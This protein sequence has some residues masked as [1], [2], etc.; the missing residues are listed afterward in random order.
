VKIGLPNIPPAVVAVA[1]VLLAG[2]LVPSS[3]RAGERE[4]DLEAAAARAGLVK[5]H[6][7][8]GHICRGVVYARGGAAWEAGCRHVAS[9][10]GV[11]VIQWPAPGISANDSRITRVGEAEIHGDPD[12]VARVLSLVAGR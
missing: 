5:V 6:E 2:I 10:P 1:A 11:V 9:T 12:E 7:Y 3:R 4:P 8:R